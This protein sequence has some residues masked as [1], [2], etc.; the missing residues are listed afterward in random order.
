[1]CAINNYSIARSLNKNRYIITDYRT[2]YVHFSVT[3][4]TFIICS[5]NA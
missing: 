1:M 5:C 3:D 4:I 2:I